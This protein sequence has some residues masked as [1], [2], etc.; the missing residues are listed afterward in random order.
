MRIPLAA[1]VT[2]VDAV[3]L[4]SLFS[5]KNR[6]DVTKEPIKLGY[7]GP[8]T[9]SSA[10]YGS[11][12]A[13]SLAIEEINSAGGIQGRKVMLIAEDGKCNGK[14]AVTAVNKLIHIDKVQIILGGHCSPESLAIA[15]IVEQNKV[16]MLA[17]IS[18]S[19]LLTHAGDYVFR[20]TPVSTVQ[21]E[22]IAEAAKNKL[23]VERFAVIYE[24]TDYARPIAEK[25]KLEFE[26]RNGQIVLYEA[27]NPGDIDFRT[28]L[29]KARSAEPDAL[30]LS[31]QTPDAVFHFV[32]QVK[33]LG[34]SVKLFGNDVFA[35]QAI[36]DQA[37][38]LFEGAVIAAPHFDES[39]PLTKKFIENYNKRYGTQHLPHGIWTAESY[40]AVFL[41]KKCIEEYGEL[42]DQVKR[43]LYN[44]KDF[45]GASGKISI[46]QNGDGI[47]E[48]YLKTIK[49]GKIVDFPN[50]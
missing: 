41:V 19:P 33:E 29:L 45:V 42:P 48:Y 50:R 43:C 35:T 49:K 46:D 3:L 8:M 5:C 30:F 1:L 17:S 34:L 6:Q 24:Q 11:F 21:S 40:D 25:L 23:G 38:E 39:N 20:T 27:Y 9:G 47:R 44:I 15:P 7:I 10:K 14:E 31:A 2:L 36:I 16:V 37:P 12:E 32:K 22:I 26:K 28:L 18:S 13:V 4:I